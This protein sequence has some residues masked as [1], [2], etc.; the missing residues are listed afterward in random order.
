M[1]REQNTEPAPPREDLSGGARFGPSDSHQD[2]FPPG[3]GDPGV[4][5]GCTSG[6]LGP[7][8]ASRP[9]GCRT[10]AGWRDGAPAP[11]MSLMVP[12]RGGGCWGCSLGSVGNGVGV[13]EKLG[14]RLRSHCQPEGFKPNPSSCA[15][16]PG[17]RKRPRPSEGG[18]A[19][20]GLASVCGVRLWVRAKF[21]NVYPRVASG[22]HAGPAL[23][24]HPLLPPG[25]DRLV[26][27]LPAK[28]TRCP[29]QLGPDGMRAPL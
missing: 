7:P 11:S 26:S 25:T 4:D 2:G 22:I 15:P 9:G 3:T 13:S 1:T 12:R 21:T 16:R 5:L 6:A 19:V 8:Q 28:A 10:A 17:G 14:T 18:G 27:K 20:L 23:G 24:A 29:V